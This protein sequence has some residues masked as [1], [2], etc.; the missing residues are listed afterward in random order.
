MLINHWHHIWKVHKGPIFSAMAQLFQTQWAI[1]PNGFEFWA[2]PCMKMDQLTILMTY[3]AASP[4]LISSSL[5]A[6]YKDREYILFAFYLTCLVLSPRKRKLLKTER[7]I[8]VSK[9]V[10]MVT[11][12]CY[13]S[14]CKF[15]LHGKLHVQWP[16]F[17][18][19]S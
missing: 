1:F 7:G 9:N 8:I 10:L 6:F 5:E 14:F 19:N 13:I 12:L 2:E 17:T 3:S 11:G 15:C 18:K 4:D 16:V